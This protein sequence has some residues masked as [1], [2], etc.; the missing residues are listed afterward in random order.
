MIFG[1]KNNSLKIISGFI[2]VATA[3]IF[4]QVVVSCGGASAP[5]PDEPDAINQ[6][7]PFPVPTTLNC[8]AGTNLSYENFGAQFLRRY[9][10]GCHS[11]NLA[12]ED[13]QG[14]PDAVNFDSSTD[15]ISLRVEMIQYAGADDASMPPGISILKDERALFREWLNCGAP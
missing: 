8:P 3:G 2:V 12:G 10:S 4:M 13:R 7:N 15:A 6:N 5:D 9:C 11:V 1:K 14:A